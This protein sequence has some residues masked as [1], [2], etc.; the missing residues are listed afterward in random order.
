LAGRYP[1]TAWGWVFNTILRGP[2]PESSLSEA[3]G[4]IMPSGPVTNDERDDDYEGDDS[5]SIWEQ[6][7]LQVPGGAKPSRNTYPETT[8]P[9]ASFLARVD[10]DNIQ[11]NDN[12]YETFTQEDYMNEFTTKLATI[13]NGAPTRTSDIQSAPPPVIIQ[14]SPERISSLCN[15]ENENVPFNPNVADPISSI[16]PQFEAP[17]MNP[18]PAVDFISSQ[19]ALMNM[20]DNQVNNL[21]RMNLM[22]PVISDNLNKIVIQPAVKPKTRAS[23]PSPSTPKIGTRNSTRNAP[24]VD[25]AAIAKGKV[26]HTSTTW[27]NPMSIHNAVDKRMKAAPTGPYMDASLE[28]IDKEMKN[29]IEI[30]DSISAIALEH[31]TSEQSRRARRKFL[32]LVNKHK[33][34][35]SFNKV[36]KQWIN[37]TAN[38]RKFYDDEPRDIASSMVKSVT[39]LVNLFM[40][41]AYDMEMEVHDVPGSFLKIK[42]TKVQPPFGFVGPEL[43]RLFPEF[44]IM[45][46]PQRNLYFWLKK[47]NYGTNKAFKR[48]YDTMPAVSE[49]TTYINEQYRCNLL[50]FVRCPTEVHCADLLTK[51]HSGARVNELL[52]LL[53]WSSQRS[54]GV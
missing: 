28:T 2:N 1:D 37:G 22:T 50:R 7:T 52:R 6:P 4:P 29:I 53:S 42:R 18:T 24:S 23:R 33:A 47:Y 32:F 13:T 17:T 44:K 51:V 19:Y 15:N 36:E 34:D 10:K 21:P 3:I 12:S 25:Y 40:V 54:E 46:S 9:D 43:Q 26:I 20:S 30:H 45:I 16:I 35:E 49:T 38:S 14:S 41:A 8:I 5:E 11:Y 31:L 27:T 39:T 48:L